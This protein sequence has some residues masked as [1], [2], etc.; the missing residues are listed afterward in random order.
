MVM[1]GRAHPAERARTVVLAASVA[2]VVGLTGGVAA[3][4]A[5][6]H[7]HATT[8]STTPTNSTNAPA[9][10]SDPNATPEQVPSWFNGGS[11]SAVP[12]PG[13]RGGRSDTTS[14]GS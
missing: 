5:F 1:R 8:T 14:R 3:Q 11:S 9:A 10:T 2:G 6:S 7:A 13:F 12:S 4:A